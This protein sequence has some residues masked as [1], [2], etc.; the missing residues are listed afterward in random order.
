[1]V[2]PWDMPQQIIDWP[3]VG[4]A[5]ADQFWYDKLENHL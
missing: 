5:L 4:R 2:Q 1:M 3:L